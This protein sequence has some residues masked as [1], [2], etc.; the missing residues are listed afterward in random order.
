MPWPTTGIHGF[1][2]LRR[3]LRISTQC[4]ALIRSISW[5]GGRFGHGRPGGS[6]L[7]LNPLL[8]VGIPAFAAPKNLVAWS[9]FQTAQ[10]VGALTR[11]GAQRFFLVPKIFP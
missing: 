9:S 11:V 2:S 8:R 6:A 7:H 3:T 1:Q 4:A 5:G 10:L